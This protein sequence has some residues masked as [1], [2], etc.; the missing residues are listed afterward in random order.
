[1]APPAGTVA[2]TLTM[3]SSNSNTRDDRFGRLRI[4]YPEVDSTMEV[5]AKLARCGAPHGTVVEARMQTAGRGRHGRQWITMPGGALLTSWILRFAVRHADGGALSPLVALATIRAITSLAL[6]APISLKWPND[7]LV[8]GRKVAGI[9]LRAHHSSHE[10]SIIAGIGVNLRPDAIPE[11]MAGSA[12]S[13]WN[14]TITAGHMLDAI[15]ANLEPIARTYGRYGRI[16]AT[17]LDEMNTLLAWRDQPV[18]VQS[19]DGKLTGIAC[20]IDVDGSL[21]LRDSGQSEVRRVRIG[22]IVRGPRPIA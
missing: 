18:T 14:P 20:G 10:Q 15:A 19:G 2:K 17:D 5:A 9:L 7:V 13:E 16:A 1:M 12:V 3:T 8:D 4:W 6:N 21:L 11:G 22:E